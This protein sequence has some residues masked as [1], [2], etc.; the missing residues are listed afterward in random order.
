ME[1]TWIG[2]FICG[3]IAAF[4]N[5]KK[6]RTERDIKENYI[7]TEFLLFIWGYIGLFFIVYRW[8]WS[9]IY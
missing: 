7:S 5:Y 6:Y 8:I 3:L 9:K 1:I 4:I 2:W